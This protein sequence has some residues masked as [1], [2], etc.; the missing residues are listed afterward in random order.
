MPVEKETESKKKMTRSAKAKAVA[1][2]LLDN[3]EEG[4][5]RL[6]KD[7]TDT[8]RA[9]LI[10]KHIYIT[11]AVASELARKYTTIRIDREELAQAGALG[12]VEAGMNY[13]PTKGASFAHFASIW[14]YRFEESRL[15][16]TYLIRLTR[17]DRQTAAKKPKGVYDPSLAWLELDRAE[18]L[19]I[20]DPSSNDPAQVFLRGELDDAKERIMVTT[21]RLIS[22]LPMDEQCVIR[23]YIFLARKGI[24][25]WSRVAKEEE[26]PERQVYRIR[27]RAI[28]K[29]ATQLKIECK[30]E[31]ELLGIDIPFGEN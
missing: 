10:V 28:T 5:E 26:I 4:E 9:D 14:I 20:A 29:I 12:L 31:L 18:S 3:N 16:K 1:R 22:E 17:K 21:A 19:E 24:V 2:M 30:D 25:S 6:K 8:E 27:D 13:D 7:L 15:A 11:R 23:Q